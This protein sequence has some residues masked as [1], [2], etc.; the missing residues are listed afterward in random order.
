MATK[1]ITSPMIFFG[2]VDSLKTRS[3][4]IAEPKTTETLVNANTV[5]SV[6]PV[7]VYARRRK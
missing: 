4:T 3:P 2:V 1:A 6:H 5:V 7:V